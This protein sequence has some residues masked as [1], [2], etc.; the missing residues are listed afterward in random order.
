VAGPPWASRRASEDP[1]ALFAVLTKGRPSRGVI[2]PTSTDHPARR[3]ILKEDK[4]AR[5]KKKK[6]TTTGR[7]GKIS[8]ASPARLLVG[9]RVFSYH[10]SPHV[11]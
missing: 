11:G 1:S 5:E 7:I 2:L 8:L 3:E 6:R 9:R 10:N 4:S